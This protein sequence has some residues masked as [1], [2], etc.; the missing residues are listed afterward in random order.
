MSNAFLAYFRNG[1]D[2]HDCLQDV[3]D[4]NSPGVYYF[5]VL[6]RSPQQDEC[7]CLIVHR[8][9]HASRCAL[10]DMLLGSMKFCDIRR[11]AGLSVMQSL[12]YVRMLSKLWRESMLHV[13][14]TPDDVADELR[15]CAQESER[16][17]LERMR[18]FRSVDLIAILHASVAKDADGDG[19]SAALVLPHERVGDGDSDS[20]D[21]AEDESCVVYKRCESTEPRQDAIQKL[22]GIG[23]SMRRGSLPEAYMSSFMSRNVPW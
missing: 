12:K 16:D 11:I 8:K 3:L 17:C 22:R 14:H 10:W 6:I 21:K 23:Q 1:Y 18:V 13:S 19:N 4:A 20:E 15:E 2:A 7:C 9:G 5:E